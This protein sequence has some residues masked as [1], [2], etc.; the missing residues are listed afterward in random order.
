MPA[1][2]TT[3]IGPVVAPAGTMALTVV[4]VGVTSGVTGLPPLNR[5]PV[6]PDR[7][8]PVIVTVAPTAPL[9]GV[10]EVTLIT[11]NCVALVAVPSAVVTLSVAVTA[12]LGTV[13]TTCVGVAD[14]TG[15]TTV[16][17]F[18]VGVAFPIMRFVPLI[19]TLAP[20]TPLGVKLVMCGSTLKALVL[21][22]VPARFVTLIGPVVAP[23]GT[24]ALM[25]V[26]D[27]IVGAPALTPLNA[28]AVTLLRLFPAIVMTVPTAP[29][30]GVNDVTVGGRLT[31]KLV[32][33][34]AVPPAV[35][36]LSSPVTAVGGTVR[37][38]C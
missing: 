25:E 21:C 29:L 27:T 19:V 23:S 6:A 10:K 1:G 7:F 17:I 35:V 26:A 3:L 5:T 14:V 34:V 22:A 4:A 33:L 8:V 38:I 15:T 30:A 24:V 16:P 9:V 13:T 11:P 18:T 32:A 31:V 37:V 2:V 28:T 20:A 12:V 36:T